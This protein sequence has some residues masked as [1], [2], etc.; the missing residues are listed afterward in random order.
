MVV[1]EDRASIKYAFLI[2]ALPLT[3]KTNPPVYQI[4]AATI[5]NVR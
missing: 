4:M 1:Q 5:L 2:S 3:S